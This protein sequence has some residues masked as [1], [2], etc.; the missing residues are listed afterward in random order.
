MKKGDLDVTIEYEK[1]AQDIK[2]AIHFLKNLEDKLNIAA[3][4]R[5]IKER[6]EKTTIG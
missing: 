6:D 5:G 1:V 2:A 3:I 4:E